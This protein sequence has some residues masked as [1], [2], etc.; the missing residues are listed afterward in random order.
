MRLPCSYLYVPATRPERVAS[1]VRAGADAVIVDLEDTV[2]IGRKVGAREQAVEALAEA[3]AWGV[4]LWVRINAPPLREDDVRAMAG[5]PNLT[6]LVVAKA[7]TPEELIELA[8]LLAELDSALIL[9]PLVESAPAVLTVRELAR[10]PRVRRMHLGEVD[11]AADLGVDPGPDDLELLW[12]RS[13]VVSESAAEGLEAPL[14]PVSTEFRDLGTF[15]AG[16]QAIRRLGFWGR[17]CIHPAQVDVVNEVFSPT[18]EE[19]AWADDVTARLAAAERA[20]SGVAVDA[21]GR[22]IDEA[23]ARRARRVLDRRE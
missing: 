3:A 7:E 2:P 18:S 13:V 16:T 6:G 5:L 23:V 21:A 20:G 10:A 8:A 22:M 12:A 17:A 19:L 15:R 4:E 11:L 14:G 1:A 9:E